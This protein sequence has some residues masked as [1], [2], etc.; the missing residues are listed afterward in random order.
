VSCSDLQCA[1]VCCSALQRTAV[2]ILD[3]LFK[4]ARLQCVAVCVAVCCS[5]LQYVAVYCSVLQRVAAGC[6]VHSSRSIIR[7]W[8]DIFRRKTSHH[9]FRLEILLPGIFLGENVTPAQRNFSR[10]SYFLA[11]ANWRCILYCANI[12]VYSRKVIFILGMR[13]NWDGGQ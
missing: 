1:A 7:I 13:I 8:C 10:Q 3:D 6:S 9:I 4:N 12:I 2:Y 11:N 5:V